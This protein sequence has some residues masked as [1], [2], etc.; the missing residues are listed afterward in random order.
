MRRSVNWADDRCTA[1]TVQ[2]KPLKQPGL[3]DPSEE[4]VRVEDLVRYALG[5]FQSRGF[6]LSN[7]KLALD[8][9]LGAFRRSFERFGAEPLDDASIAEA[10][11]ESGALVEELPGYV[12][13]H[14]FRVV[15]P[16]EL[17]ESSLRFY[18]E[19]EETEGSEES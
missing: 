7:R 16:E 14:P 8:R 12:A 15:V 17:A 10:L 11:G 19:T 2:R 4:D 5:D 1:M 18:N 6:E 9:L 13:K 3:F